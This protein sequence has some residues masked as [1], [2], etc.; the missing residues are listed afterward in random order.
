MRRTWSR[1]L[2]PLGLAAAFVASA[3][4]YADCSSPAGPEGSLDYNTSTHAFQYCDNTNTWQP[5]ATGAGGGGFFDHI[6]SGTTNVYV[7]STTLT[8]SFTTN[9]VVANYLDNQG[10]F[11]M[12]GISMTTNQLSATTGYFSGRVGISNA[13]PIARLDVIGTIS[14]SDAIQVS[15]SSLTC[16]AAIKGAIRYSNTSS[17]IEY[18]QGAA[19]GRT[20]GA[21]IAT[22]TT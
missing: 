8:V 12:T 5:I 15:G 2:R 20:S 21:P 16:S 14:A 17:T 10:R 4:A 22:R 7:N 19:R 1:W 18:C 9:D 13:V 11:V 6:I 3:T